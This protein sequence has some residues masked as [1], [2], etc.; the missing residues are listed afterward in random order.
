MC[1]WV[2][3]TVATMSSSRASSSS[4]EPEVV[5]KKTK[6][7]KG[8]QK[9]VRLADPAAQ[10]DEDARN[11][12][13]DPNWDYQPPPGY[14]LMKHKVEQSEFDWD[15]INND[16]NLELWVVRVPDG[17]RARSTVLG[18]HPVTSFGV[19]AA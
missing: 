8:K 17:V 18:V 12:G 19:Y 16:D 3:A 6:K 14:T 2:S 4:P 5:S 7:G 11:E 15:T 9:K 13:D 10:V 1:A